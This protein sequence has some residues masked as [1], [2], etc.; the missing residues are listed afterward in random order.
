M[1]KILLQNRRRT[2]EFS[3]EV[4]KVGLEKKEEL[5]SLKLRAMNDVA[6]A[7]GR[8]FDLSLSQLI[9]D[10]N[11]PRKQFINIE[12]L[13]ESIKEKGILQPLVVK[14]RNKKGEYQIIVGER[15]YHAAKMAGL[16]VLPCIIR[17]EEDAN[18]LILQLLENDQREQVPPLEEAH[19]IERLIAEMGLSKKQIAKEL[20]RDAAWVSMRLGLLEGSDAIRNL[21][22]T[23]KVT[24][25][26]TLHEL[27]QLEQ[28]HPHKAEEALLRFKAQDFVGNFRAL[29][30]DFRAQKNAGASKSSLS[31]GSYHRVKKDEIKGQHWWLYL[32]GKRKPLKLILD[33]DLARM[34]RRTLDG[35]LRSV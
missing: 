28:E 1:K 7:H 12:G 17:D 3:Q 14:P 30:Q 5:M 21:L 10:P 13:A 15:R 4:E 25:L 33:R 8:L 18:T 6:Q 20:G 35:F 22:Q 32:E 26:R 19:A 23:G 2:S 27:R 34:L 31:D 16:K 24:D 11:Q 29:L 9:C